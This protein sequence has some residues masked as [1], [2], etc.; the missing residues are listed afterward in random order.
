MLRKVQLRQLH[1][2][3][4]RYDLYDVVN[5]RLCAVAVVVYRRRTKCECGQLAEIQPLGDSRTLTAPQ[6]IH[7]GNMEM[8]H[9]GL[10]DLNQGKNMMCL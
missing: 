10:N 5:G 3:P 6:S 1:C 7:F 2:V 4:E 8:F 9:A